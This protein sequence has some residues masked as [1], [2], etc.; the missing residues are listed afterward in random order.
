MKGLLIK[1]ELC[2]Y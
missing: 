1:R 2:H